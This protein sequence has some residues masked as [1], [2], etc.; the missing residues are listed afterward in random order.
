MDRVKIFFQTDSQRAFSLRSAAREARRVVMEEGFW[1]LWRG[2]SATVV[3]VFPYAG[4]QFAAYDQYSRFFSRVFNAFNLRE[5]RLKESGVSRSPNNGVESA[6]K[7]RL[8]WTSKSAPH[9]NIEER[10]ETGLSFVHFAERMLAGSGAG[11]T[12][13]LATYPLDVLRA[14]MAAHTLL[15]TGIQ[16][17]ARR[18]VY[19]EGAPLIGYSADADRHYSICRP[20]VYWFPQHQGHGEGQWHEV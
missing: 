2:N 5:K 19:D 6:E 8:S 3:R 9:K 1:S 4:M 18:I 14:R 13:V 11:A 16:H 12:A 17:A 15:C 7:G 10:Q 20:G